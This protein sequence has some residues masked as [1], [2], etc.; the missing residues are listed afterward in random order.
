MLLII[1]LFIKA[2]LSVFQSVNV[3]LLTHNYFLI[4][5]KTK[6][7]MLGAKN[8]KFHFHLEASY[9][10]LQEEVYEEKLTTTLPGFISQIGGQFSF[11]LGMSLISLLQ[12]FLIPIINFI[13]NLV[14]KIKNI[15]I[16]YKKRKLSGRP[17][18]FL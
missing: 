9:E 17:N 7:A 13:G 5:F 4:N 8:K 3:I 16:F 1:Y 2:F 6:E 10:N 12:F 18:D 15:F 14:I 11:F